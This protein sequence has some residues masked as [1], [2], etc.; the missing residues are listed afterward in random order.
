MKQ[1]GSL[2]Q[3]GHPE[4]DALH[5]WLRHSLVEKPLLTISGSHSRGLA[6]NIGNE[7]GR[8]PGPSMGTGAVGGLHRPKTPPFGS[9]NSPK[10]GGGGDGGGGRWRWRWG[11]ME[12]RGGGGLEVGRE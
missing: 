4:L 9:A 5:L 8:R 7:E 10:G 11:W 6:T 1:A 12:S 3:A 2:S